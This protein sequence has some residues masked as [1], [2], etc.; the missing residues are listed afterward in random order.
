M[1]WEERVGVRP[2]TQSP[3]IS[4][5]GALIAGILLWSLEP[6]PFVQELFFLSTQNP[7]DTLIIEFLFTS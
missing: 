7:F 5:L 4:L 3:V 6:G 2:G 1:G